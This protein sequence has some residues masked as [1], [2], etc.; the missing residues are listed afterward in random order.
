VTALDLRVPAGSGC[1][2]EGQ[3]GVAH[4]LEHLVV[5]ALPDRAR[6]RVRARTGRDGT[7]FALTAVPEEAGHLVQDL[8]AAVAA[9]ALTARSIGAER[10]AIAQ[11]AWERRSGT[12][13]QMQ[14]DFLAAWWAG[15]TWAHDALGRDAV[16]AAADPGRLE[17]A[18]HEWYS[19]TATLGVAGATAGVDQVRA[20]LTD[21]SL[22]DAATQAVHHPAGRGWPGPSPRFALEW[23][24]RTSGREVSGAGFADPVGDLGAETAR[25]L[26]RTAL[27]RVGGP[28]LTSNYLGAFRASWTVGISRP[29]AAPAAERLRQGLDRATSRLASDPDLLEQARVQHL[30]RS[31]GAEATAAWLTEPPAAEPVSIGDRV[32]LVARCPAA[33]VT[34]ELNRW[35][36]QWT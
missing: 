31:E 4:L 26:A 16:L 8:L 2:V 11:E 28:V 1:E 33:A 23:R 19:A 24:D 14:Q 35:R 32:R 30:R 9:P 17:Q 21:Q 34:A 7:R 27:A 13:W 15:T 10:Y 29:G 25:D 3:E 18:H 6:H 12:G 5:V 36:A 22:S 20:A